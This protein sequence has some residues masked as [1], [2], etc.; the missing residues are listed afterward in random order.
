MTENQPQ[1]HQLLAKLEQ[2]LQKQDSFAREIEALRQD[3]EALKK[4]TTTKISEVQP[5]APPI[6]T[7]KI[8]I[9]VLR[10]IPEP[11]PAS[12]APTKATYDNKLESFIGE[13]LIS[14][15]GIIVLVLGVAIGVKYVIDH[16][17]ISPALRIALGYLL[18]FG[19]LGF[20]FRFRAQY[21]EYSA[22]LMS[23]ATTIF[24]FITYAAY[25]FYHLYPVA[26]TFV[27]MFA[28]T[29]FTVLASLYYN[30]V[31]IALL[32]LV[33]AYALP[34]LLGDDPER[35]GILFAY[36]ALV[37]IGIL[38]LAISRN[39]KL[40][41]VAAFFWTWL[42]FIT[43]FL[44]YFD[45]N[46]HFGLALGF[47]TLFFSIFYATFL[48]YKLSKAAEMS[49]GDEILLVANSLLFFGFSI[50]AAI[51][52]FDGDAFSGLIAFVNALI[53]AMVALALYQQRPNLHKI[54]QFLGCLSLAFF[55][56]AIPLQFD[57]NWVTILWSL[58]AISLFALGR[59]YKITFLEISA[60]IVMGL[61][62]L[63]LANGWLFLYDGYVPEL[64]ETRIPLLLNFNFFTG[65]LFCAVFAGIN[66]LHHRF[67]AQSPGI[68]DQ[69]QNTFLASML[70][71]TLVVALYF[72][73]FCEISTYWSQQYTHTLMLQRES[74]QPSSSIPSRADLEL[75]RGVWLINYSLFFIAVLS[76][77]NW[78][79]IKSKGLTSL[80]LG[81]NIAMLLVF[82]T[83][84]LVLLNHLQD[85]YLH[86]QNA[87]Y[88]SAFNVG[89]RYVSLLFV[90]LLLSS[91]IVYLSE[92]SLSE[93]LRSAYEIFVHGSILWICSNEILLLNTT[94]ANKLGLSLLWGCYALALIIL[95]I[96]KRK[97][98]L[99]ISGM[100]L[101][102]ATLLKLFF[103]DIEHL[104]TIPK[105]VIFVALGML[106]L[107]VSYLYNRYKVWL[108]PE[109][110]PTSLSPDHQKSSHSN[111]E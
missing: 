51:W 23:G 7:P 62:S 58:E 38:V 26:L 43:W 96:W 105:T 102:G 47:L 60:F 9:P 8:P 18:G 56:I 87:Y 84:G 93:E 59:V 19:L 15:I 39:W 44:E 52:R 85:S 32:G 89:I 108:N 46:Q 110:E 48:A 17:L 88:H 76:F 66:Y 57:G 55:T 13:N 82:L 99:R 100:F 72:T 73:F 63:C 6:P 37:N 111:N 91:G 49:G 71:A 4:P 33:G 107:L 101:F 40:L 16:N 2:L 24:Y 30:N 25:S 45:P 80:C 5:A 94:L 1:L 54:S 42:I 53:H 3:I 50:Y 29:V 90:A 68:K 97:P 12:S 98:H 86:P 10:P 81:L 106:L 34:Y 36:N 95:G 61:S 31:F 65:L 109:Q 69:Q 14:K 67:V 28:F 35:I 20:A 103:Y 22:V 74:P 70:G 78:F 92:T 27:L 79:K 64:P 11:T 104:A 77:V 83:L 75:F 21:V 41:N